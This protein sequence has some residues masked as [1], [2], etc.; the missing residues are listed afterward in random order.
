MERTVEQSYELLGESGVKLVSL[1]GER[2]NI[3]G[4][5]IVGHGGQSAVT[6][7]RGSLA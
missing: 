5:V 3:T 1:N 4:Q 2:T 6:A 7:L